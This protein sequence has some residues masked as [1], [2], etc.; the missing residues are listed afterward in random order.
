MSLIENHFL[1]FDSKIPFIKSLA[2]FE[3]DFFPLKL[4][5]PNTIF[6]K[7]F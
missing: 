2:P 6:S 3:I 4:Y 1:G 7:S 5:S